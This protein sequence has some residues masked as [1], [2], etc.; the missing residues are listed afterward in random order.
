M[1]VV[2]HQHP[3]AAAS[4]RP[5]LRN[6]P[7]VFAFALLGLLLLGAVGY[8]YVAGWEHP[9]AS[10]WYAKAPLPVAQLGARTAWYSD[11]SALANG[12]AA[13][14][15][16]QEL[17]EDDFDHALDLVNRRLLI[18]RLA[19]EYDVEVTQDEVNVE[20]V[21]DD[22]LHEFLAEAKWDLDAYREYVLEP[23][24]LSQRVEE[25]LMM[26][27]KYQAG[28]LEDIA[29]LQAKLE[30]GIAFE[31]V[32][33]QYSEDSS[34]QAKG[35]LGY[36]LPSEVDAGLA[37][38]FALEIGGV[39]EVLEASDAFWIVRVEDIANE[40]D[41]DRYFLRGIAVKKQG[42]AEI[43]DQLIE[44]HDMVVFVRN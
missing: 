6:L 29:A 31:D 40:V 9:S 30:L 42:I 12:F 43:V 3:A 25:Q 18:A 24:V 21:E 13:S 44:E 28:A 32:A 35:S 15:G 41:G 7:F 2:W 27:R 17:T 8:F 22:A 19:D 38:A 5:P 23:F 34:A 26:D 20:L 37:S 33:Q 16:H 11:L 10:H 36:V 14:E 4:A 1:T 39:S